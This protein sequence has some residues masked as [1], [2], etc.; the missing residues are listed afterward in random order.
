MDAYTIAK[1][2]DREGKFP[3]HI[4]YGTSPLLVRAANMLRRQADYIKQL[5]EGLDSSIKLNKAQ[6]ERQ[7]DN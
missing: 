1:D 6:A 5:E 4:C 2:L 7:N 3:G